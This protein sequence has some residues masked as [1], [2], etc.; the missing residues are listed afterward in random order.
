MVYK[1]Y[2]GSP[3]NDYSVDGSAATT[4][5]YL[6]SVFNMPYRVIYTRYPYRYLKRL[7]RRF[8][9]GKVKGTLLSY[10][11]GTSDAHCTSMPEWLYS[12]LFDIQPIYVE[13]YN[14]EETK[15]LTKRLIR[16][17]IAALEAY[18]ISKP[19]LSLP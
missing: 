7:I 2:L 14:N 9:R 6:I 11:R 1:K 17:I 4:H 18:Y 12:F 10:L 5:F 8:I 19:F 13:P 16:E 3:I 15:P